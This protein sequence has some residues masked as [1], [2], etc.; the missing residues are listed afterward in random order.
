[1]AK[2]QKSVLERESQRDLLG[3]TEGAPI[4]KAYEATA[5]RLRVAKAYKM[6][7]GGAFVRSESGRYFQ[8]EAPVFSS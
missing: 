7:V 8:V 3:G 4:M 6:Y 5:E 1:M 2:N